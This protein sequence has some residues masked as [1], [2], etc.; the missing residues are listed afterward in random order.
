MDLGSPNDYARLFIDEGE[1]LAPLLRREA[2]RNGHRA[3]VQRLLAG[4]EG[5]CFSE[6]TDKI[7]QSFDLSDR[8]IEVLQLAATG[9][10]NREIGV[11]LFISEATVKRHMNHLLRK[12]EAANRIQATE[13]AREIGL[14]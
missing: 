5:A 8:E 11:R 2:L 3:F 6:S 4:I 1:E 12:L 14:L 10:P 13:R 7:D 9:M